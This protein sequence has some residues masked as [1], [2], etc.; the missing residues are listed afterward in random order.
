MARQFGIGTRIGSAIALPVSVIALAATSSVAFADEPTAEAPMAV[1]APA[2]SKPLCGRGDIREP[3]IQG[4]VPAG[5]TAAYNCGVRRIGQLPRVGSVQGYGNCAYVRP[6]GTRAG[7]T[8]YVID[9]SNPA[10]PKEVGSFPVKSASETMRVVVAPDRAILVSGSSVYDIGNCLEPKLMGEIKWPPLALG[11]GPPLGGGGGMGILPHDLRINHAGT[12][13]YGSQSLWEADISDLSNPENWTITDHRCALATEVAGPWQALHR[14]AES[15]G[16]SLC[17]DQRGK[18]GADYRLGSSGIQASLLWP[19]ISHGISVSSDD[20]RVYIGEQSGGAGMAISRGRP[21]LRV[22]DMSQTPLKLLGE[23]DGSGHSVDWFRVN[24]REY[25]LHANEGG[26]VG[27]GM[28]LGSGAGG[29]N[30]CQP[31][32]RHHTLGWAFDALISEVTD[33]TAPR[34]VSRLSVDINEPENCADR[35]ASGSDPW[36][37]YHMIDNPMDATFA[38]VNFNSAGLR[39][40]DIRKPEAPVEVA[41]FNHGP[42]VHGGVGHYD[43]ARGLIYAAGNSGLWILELEP[44]V[45]KQLGL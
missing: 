28:R 17:A 13:V 30:T 15:V 31:H 10:K 7:T 3:G 36:I 12:K 11:M 27:I 5:K 44:Q 39:I 14:H 34:N 20:E 4:N 29:G 25:V 9:V 1:L 38:A 21:K 23:T 26:S 40:F 33:P 2:A 8:V 35:K 22:L 6:R 18:R 19:M 16:L 24:G 32:P 42:M 45:R 43:A 37:A 41:Y